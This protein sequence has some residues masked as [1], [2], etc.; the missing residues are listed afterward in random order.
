MDDYG[1]KT[2]RLIEGKGALFTNAEKWD[3]GSPDMKGELL[4]KGEL[5]K[6]GGWIRHTDKGMLI[7]LGIDKF[8]RNR[9][10]N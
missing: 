7:S 1:Y 6:I 4:Y 8:K 9:D 5:I 2:K 10:G 3:E